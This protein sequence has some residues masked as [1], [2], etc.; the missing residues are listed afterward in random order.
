VPQRGFGRHRQP[1]RAHEIANDRRSLRPFELPILLP[2]VDALLELR[3]ETARLGE[4]IAARGAVHAMQL[5]AQSRDSLRR[6]RV[7]GQLSSQI[8]EQRDCAGA[9][10]AKTL[11]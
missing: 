8:L 10:L 2:R 6:T 9:G 3:R 7:G 4:T 11:A 5:T 1:Q